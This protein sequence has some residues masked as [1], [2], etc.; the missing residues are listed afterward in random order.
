MM[1]QAHIWVL[2]STV[3]DVP[4]VHVA[5]WTHLAMLNARFNSTWHAPQQHLCFYLLLS[6]CP[7]PHPLIQDVRVEEMLSF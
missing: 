6:C 3:N 5:I 1:F 2:N 7:S 4:Q